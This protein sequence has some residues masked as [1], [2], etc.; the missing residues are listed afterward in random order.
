M[1]GLEWQEPR[2]GDR[3]RG[4]YE[5][6]MSSSVKTR[7]GGVHDVWKGQATS[8]AQLDSARLL[9]DVSRSVSAIN[10][11]QRALS[12][13]T[14]SSPLLAF[15]RDSLPLLDLSQQYASIKR[16]PFLGATMG[17]STFLKDIM[18]TKKLA[19]G[20][21]DVFPASSFVA[22]LPRHPLPLSSRTF[23]S[24][25]PRVGGITSS[26]LALREL[27]TLRLK[28][29]MPTIQP[30]SS[31][32]SFLNEFE[33]SRRFFE[34]VDSVAREWEGNALWFV[35]SSLPMGALRML[36]DLDREQVEEVILRALE[37]VIADGKFVAALREVLAE[38]PHISDF[39]RENLMHGLEHAERREHL[40]AVAPL[41]YGLEGAIISAARGHA[42]IDAERRLLSNPRKKLD[43]VEAIVREMELDHEFRR[44]L[45]RRVFG[46]GG[47][48]FRHGDADGGERR[49]ALLAIV[50]LSGWI[51]AFMGLSARSVLVDLMSDELPRIVECID[52]PVREQH[53]VVPMDEPSL[54]N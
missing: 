17:A 53:E 18:A 49:Q 26:L 47:N 25:L 38:A 30:L 7:T 12:L 33:K 2:S 8:V 9:A 3:V 32:I 14:D 16:S 35:L 11:T 29:Q 15:K 40:R 54:V 19:V 1:P 51:D 34:A 42:V 21:A 6:L 50:A 23:A 27:G 48:F 24:Q 52:Q 20:L 5:L 22:Q 37:A 36:V 41:M 39:Q 43:C 10:D 28:V 46:T 44:F 13:L 31:T 45:H 4:Y